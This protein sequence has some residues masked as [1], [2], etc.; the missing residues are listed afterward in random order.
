MWGRRFRLPTHMFYRRRLPHW[1]PDI[2]EAT[3]LFVTWRL[4]GSIPRTRL[5]P[6]ASAQLSAGRRFLALD[7]E[8]DQA[9]LGPVWLRDPR[10]AGVVAQAFHHGERGRDFYQLRAWVIM[11]N[12]VHLV[13]LPKTPLLRLPGG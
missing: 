8:V 1:H 13:L 2:S 11:P 9:A 4:S 3:F 5:S 7:R 6:P 12:H 10:V